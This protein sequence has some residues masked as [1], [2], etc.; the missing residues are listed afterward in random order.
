MN[1][2][3]V[4]WDLVL[5]ARPACFEPCSKPHNSSLSPLCSL[6]T[7]CWHGIYKLLSVQDLRFGWL[8]RLT[9]TTTGEACICPPWWFCQNCRQEKELPS[10]VP[11]GALQR[12][13]P[14]V[15][16]WLLKHLCKS[17]W[18]CVLCAKC[19]RYYVPRE[20]LSDWEFLCMLVP[21]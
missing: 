9:R 17:S 2:T 18:R 4:L 19:L 13:C 1:T 5:P 8:T 7:D 10:K 12:S 21:Y 3:A 20:Y 15:P 14:H 6:Q 16:V 11:F